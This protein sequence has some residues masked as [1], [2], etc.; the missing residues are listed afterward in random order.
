MG[1]IEPNITGGEITNF[2][3]GSEYTTERFVTNAAINP[4]NSGGPS[5]SAGRQGRR[6]EH[7]RA[8]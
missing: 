7:G 3:S 6:P 5:I 1:M 4:G 2:V 8:V